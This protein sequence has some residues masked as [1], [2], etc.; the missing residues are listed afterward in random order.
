MFFI[1]SKTV[2]FLTTPLVIIVLL[3]IASVLVKKEALKRRLFWSGLGLLLLGSNAFIANEAMKLWEVSPVPFESVI[4]KY[5][6]AVVL[7]G[8]VQGDT[9]LKDRAFLGKGGDRLYHTLL[10]YNRGLIERVFITGGSG[11]LI[12]VGQIE[13]KEMAEVLEEMGIPADRIEYETNARNTH[14]NAVE[15]AKFL[16]KD[17]R[18]QECLLITSSYHMRRARASF[19]KEGFAM[20]VFSVDIYTH[21]R[22]FYPN[23]FIVPSLGALQKWHVIAKEA[24]GY[25]AYW[26]MGYI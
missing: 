5:K 14:E 19:E 15:T 3:L 9:E 11:R 13:A 17:Y 24:V 10:L 21:R 8:V 26:V 23:L 25:A 6:V 7:S 16:K 18:P 1:L 12:D 20:D 22:R 2:N 4:K